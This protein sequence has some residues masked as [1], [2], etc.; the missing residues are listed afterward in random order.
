MKLSTW[1]RK[2]H[3]LPL[4]VRLALT[5]L[6]VTA[7][8]MAVL[9]S[10]LLVGVRLYEANRRST[11]LEGQADLYALLADELIAASGNLQAVTPVL[12][13][14]SVGSGDVAVRVFG[15]AGQIFG[16]SGSN[17]PF[18]SRSVASLLTSGVPQVLLSEDSDRRYSSR[19]IKWNGRL[20]GVIEVSQS[21][22]E[23][24][25]LYFLLRRV[26]TQSILIALV[27]AVVGAIIVARW[28]ARLTRG[29]RYTA[30]R[31]ASGDLTE[32]ARERGPDEFVQLTR[33]LNTMT[34][35]LADR[36][37][38]I[39]AQSAAQRRFYRDISHELR[40]PLM[41][42]G[43][44]LENIE[45]AEPGPEQT[46]ALAAMHG[47]IARL[48]RLADELLRSDSAPAI[49][50]GD[51]QPIDLAALV[52]EIT[53]NLAGRARRGGVD[54]GVEA[55][56]G[57]MTVLGDRDRLKQAILNLLDNALRATPPGGSIAVTLLEQAGQAVI[58]VVDSGMGIPEDLRAKV[59][60]RGVRGA[61]GGSGLGLAIVRAII[62]AHG[63]TALLLPSQ[64]G[65]HFQLSLPAGVR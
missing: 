56:G 31:V 34:D 43:G 61:D 7:I 22:T 11:E 58:D 48:G 65:A 18:P 14:R 38:R 1:L 20:V 3:A 62:E 46:R 53:A 55:P 4:V 30:E 15:S 37:A 21:T 49:A 19:P 57:P 40:T 8:A 27:A 17:A 28:L 24:Q 59:W 63:G 23:E 25:R 52:G 42:L 47:E 6:L 54:L 5:L 45:D 2:Q 32:R 51:R 26:A 64:E 60:E 36:L 50:I 12:V 39:E 16:A 33:A 10:G 29:L 13:S 9:I 35:Q 44:Y 41:A